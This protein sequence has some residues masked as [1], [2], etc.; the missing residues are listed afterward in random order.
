MNAIFE[1]KLPYRHAISL[2]LAALTLGFFALYV[3]LN[4]QPSKSMVGGEVSSHSGTS[5]NG[6][7]ELGLVAGN[8]L[9]TITICHVNRYTFFRHG[10]FRRSLHHP[11]IHIRRCCKFGRM[12]EQSTVSGRYRHHEHSPYA[13]GL[14]CCSGGLGGWRIRGGSGNAY[15]DLPSRVLFPH[16]RPQVL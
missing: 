15:R 3:I 8:I 5:L 1:S 16:H 12:A 6:L 9:R 14:I 2:F 11:T 10:I 13:F 7:F 4:G